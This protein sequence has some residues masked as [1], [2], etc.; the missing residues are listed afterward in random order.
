MDNSVDYTIVIGMI[1]IGIGGMFQVNYWYIPVLL[2]VKAI[3][4]N[5]GNRMEIHFSTY[6]CGRK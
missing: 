3:W 4:W 6:C 1:V 2:F 5:R